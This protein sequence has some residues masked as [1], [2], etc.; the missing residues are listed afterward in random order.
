MAKVKLKKIIADSKWQGP[1]R[2]IVGAVIAGLGVKCMVDGATK[3]AYGA[4]TE[5]TSHVYCKLIDRLISKGQLKTEDFND[6]LMEV[7]DEEDDD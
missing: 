7:A 4:G 3:Y 1:L 2:S 6:T 5:Q